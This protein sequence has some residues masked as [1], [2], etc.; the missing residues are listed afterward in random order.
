V[1]V[2]SRRVR[3]I[4]RK[5][6]REY[7]H[8]GFIIWTMAIFPLIFLIQPLVVVFV[9]PPSASAEL[10]HGH[11][12]LYMLGIPA[13]VPA[14]VA[15]YAVVG[16]RQQ[17]TLEPLLTTP[18]RREEFLLGKA[19]AAL[20][21]SVAIAYAVY[22][23][24][25]ACVWLFAEPAVAAAL[26]RAPDVLAQLLFT[27]LLAGW[28][29]WIGIAISARASDFRVAQQLGI[30]AGLPTALVAALIAFDVI[31]ATLGLAVGLAAALLLG[32]RLGWRIM[33]AAFDR[34]RLLTGT[35]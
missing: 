3:A 31:H 10:S 11:P 13:L 7:R 22:A 27:P 14:A 15:A 17:G 34:E 12:L 20:A 5:E 29:I 30:L 35:R 23:L 19:L 6:L 32:N 18:I 25:L 21:P 9:L 26:L 8:N 2:S 1:K 16:E 28:S 24:F 4:V 33:A